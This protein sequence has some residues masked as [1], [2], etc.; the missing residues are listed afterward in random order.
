MGSSTKYLVGGYNREFRKVGKE[1]SASLANQKERFNE[2]LDHWTDVIDSGIPFHLLG[3]F[4][5][6]V[7]KWK[8]LEKGGSQYQKLVDKLYSRIL[9]RGVTKTVNKPTRHRGQF[10][11]ILDLHFTN[12]LEKTGI[13]SICNDTQSDYNGIMVVRKG[14]GGKTPNVIRARSLKKINWNI[15]RNQLYCMPLGHIL[16]IQDVDE[17]VNQL[18]AAV[19]ICL[20]SQAPVNIIN[21]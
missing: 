2:F 3:D 20:D 13:T 17:Y 1:G 5:L 14:E 21:V 7:L 10:S 11:S 12:D 4:N 16:H 15:A 6:D 8:Q 19:Q 9:S 18:T